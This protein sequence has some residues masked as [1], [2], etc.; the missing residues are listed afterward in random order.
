MTSEDHDKI[1]D[2]VIYFV[3][4]AGRYWH[5]TD[6][7]KLPTFLLRLS[8]F[9][10][11]LLASAQTTWRNTDARE[12]EASKKAFEEWRKAAKFYLFMGHPHL[13]SNAF[14]AGWQAHSTVAASPDP[15]LA[16]RI[17]DVP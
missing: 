4:K 11:T 17:T 10:Q 2:L 12:R 16:E 8:R 6:I 7:T 13:A 5:T 15:L 14:E 9:V 1:E 3:A